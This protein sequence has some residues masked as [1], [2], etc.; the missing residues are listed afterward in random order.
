[1]LPIAAPPLLGSG[2]VLSIIFLLIKLLLLCEVVP[3]PSLY[4]VSAV[5]DH[6]TSKKMNER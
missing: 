6:L 1:V 2:W 4:A 3:L 5:V